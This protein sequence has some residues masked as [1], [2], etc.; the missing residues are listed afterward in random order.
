M[1]KN[2]ESQNNYKVKDIINP[3]EYILSK[4]I[5]GSVNIGGIHY[6]TL[7]ACLRIL[8]ELH[9][10]NN[11]SIQLEGIEDLDLN[12]PQLTND[13]YEYIQV[14]TSKNKLDAGTFW[15][16]GVLQN[17]IEIYKNEPKSKFK[18]VYNMN[19]ASGNMKDLVNNHLNDNSRKFWIDKL[20]SLRYSEIDHSQ[21]LESISF[22]LMSTIEIVNQIIKLLFQNWNVN[23]GAEEQFL[24]SLFY[25]VLAWSKDRKKITRGDIKLLF[26][27]IIDSYSKTPINEAL[28]NDWIKPVQ[29]IP[30]DK[31]YSNYYDGKAAM[32]IHI[33]QGLPAR[34]ITWEK[35]IESQLE[36]SDISVIKSS[37]GQGKSTLA[38]QVCFNLKDAYDIYQVQFC[39][40][41]N[42][43]NSIIQFIE[44]RLHI[45]QLPLIVID[46]L[47]S[48]IQGW[49]HI[50]ERTI[51]LPV[52]YLITT[53]NEDWYRYGA[54]ISKINLQLTDI[55]LSIEE[56]RNIYNQLKK[57]EKLH[58][59]V[60]SWQS[61]WEQVK[62]SG[63]L[64]E[65]T[66]LLTKGEMIQERL[67]YQISNLNRSQC[68]A[69][70][71][72]I[73][74][75]VALADCMNI[76]IR[77]SSLISHI[78]K[79]IGFQ[80]D[81]GAILK[82][83][84]NEYFLNLETK[85]IS[86]LHPVR[87]KHL[88]DLL[89]NTLP[90]EDS[91][92]SLHN[93]LDENYLFNFFINVPLFIKANAKREFYDVLG[94]NLSEK[95]F[96]DM[97]V[98][99]DGTLHIEPQ[100]YWENNR[101]IYDDVFN[102]GGIELFLTTT[103]PFTEGKSIL[104]LGNIADSLGENFSSNL[105]YLSQLRE[106]LSK[107]TI[108]DTDTFLLASSLQRFLKLRNTPI[109]SYLGLEFLIKWFNKLHLPLGL[110]SKLLSNIEIEYFVNNINTF[111]LEEAKEIALYF[112]N[113][114]EIK[115]KKYV[116]NKL[117]LLI[118]YLKEKTNSL[119]IEIV[120]NNIHIN[121]LL[122]GDDV[123]EANELSISR[124]QTIYT[125]LPFYKKYCSEAILLPYPNEEIISTVKQNSIKQ[126]SPD[127]ILNEFNRHLNQIWYTIILKNYEEPSVYNW[128]KNMIALREEAL[129][130]V[131]YCC[132]FLDSLLE[133]NKNKMNSSLKELTDESVIFGELDSTRKRYPTFNKKYFEK[134]K[135]SD[136]EKGINSWLF[137]LRNVNNQLVDFFN[138]KIDHKRHIAL[139]NL[140]ATY[141]KLENMQSCFNNMMD[142]SFKYFDTVLL[143]NREKELYERLYATM[144]Y[145]VSQIP[146]ESKPAIRVAKNI[147]KEWW[148]NQIEIQIQNLSRVLERINN[149][150]NRYKFY[151]PNRVE[152][153][154]TL[155]YVTIGIENI[156]FSNEHVLNSLLIDLSELAEFPADFYTILNVKNGVVFSGIRFQKTFF[157]KLNALLKGEKETDLS[158]LTPLPVFPNET[159]LKTLP[160]LKLGSEHANISKNREV[161]IM[162]EL[163]KLFEYRNRL[164]KKSEIELGWLKNIEQ[165]IIADINNL[166][167][168]IEDKVFFEWVQE[169]INRTNKLSTEIIL[170]QLNKATS[171]SINYL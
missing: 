93:L 123:S 120:K 9:N 51:E 110:S 143:E 147:A 50:V 47:D 171:P 66:Y 25:N 55:N 38:W 117:S 170:A 15:N 26:Q 138:P 12:R 159:T 156:D 105:N 151:I 99:L 95:S 73:L 98:A 16:L 20:S 36:N 72:E 134:N 129:K 102:T 30:Q 109:D 24:K 41:W 31:D 135:Q 53:R 22:E 49:K 90:I 63:L 29:F 148:K 101:Q 34:R 54:D 119:T 146:L 44:S 8:K 107:F 94:K 106:K 153:T 32:P 125:F 57:K 39:P 75:L 28:K 76:K 127:D 160:E 155:T 62:E 111:E 118:S 104:E 137:D 91:L 162:I 142:Y 163:W 96:S 112:L 79:T 13:N 167:T 52:K 92:I 82:E 37:S 113:V 70:K 78:N 58:E 43:A 84:K 158:N 2:K 108:K 87:S 115:Y 23:K 6:Q 65:Y 27:E 130:L 17:Y 121:Y 56:A 4:R 103:I 126:L 40:D 5:G 14:K 83:L 7:Y 132:Q 85:Y 21:F 133:G 48:I 88:V 35:K 124:I 33:A 42:S 59:E 140:K 67:K 89:H 144:Q 164:D 116:L 165:D 60:T 81:R 128:Q 161:K 74:R 1:N 64:I 149:Y 80:Q 46:G 152:E 61:I 18:L 11:A 139:V 166:S 169:G 3:L 10:E 97:V 77:T 150:D 122:Y 131:L 45:G 71:L 136:D 69:S 114:D 19:I 154:S 68:A 168:L 141:L 145:Y 157:Q 86:G 100:I